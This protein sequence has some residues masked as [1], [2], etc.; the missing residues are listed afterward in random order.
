MKPRLTMP[1]RPQSEASD[2]DP[3]NW[4]EARREKFLLEAKIVA[5]KLIGD[6]ITLPKKVTLELD[7]V[8]RPAAFKYHE[9]FRPGVTQF[10]DGP[11]EVNF[12]DSYLFDRAA[13]LLDQE[14]DLGM[15]P[16]TVLRE[17]DGQQGALVWWIDDA[18]SEVERSERAISPPDPNLLRYQQE[19]TRLFYALVENT[20]DNMKNQL[21]TLRDW[22][23][24]MIDLTRAFR[25]SRKLD[26]KFSK[27]ELT[28]PR[29][30]YQRLQELD[31]DRLIELMDGVLSTA[32]VSALLSRRDAIIKKVDADIK[33]LGEG[34]VFHNE[35]E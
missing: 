35:S 4:G 34:A 9:E 19:I 33:R 31:R 14:L 24:H 12:R 22:R 25:F 23:V 11:R 7:G 3:L 10:S 1:F 29:S 8:T 2:E 26:K 20:D 5:I 15:V 13:Y 6:G 30:L 28:L 21:V 16:V 27:K 17:V 18:I 32:Q